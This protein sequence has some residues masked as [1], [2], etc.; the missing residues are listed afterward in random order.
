MRWD[1]VCGLLDDPKTGAE[2][3]VWDGEFTRNLLKRNPRLTMYAVDVAIRPKF[4][5]LA[6]KHGDRVIAL[7][8]RTVDAAA[9]VPDG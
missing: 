2:L 9:Y 8:K 7:N 5:D 4:A 3:G 1:S 6:R